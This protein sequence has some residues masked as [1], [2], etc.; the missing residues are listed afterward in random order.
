MNLYANNHDAFDS[1]DVARAEQFAAAA[2]IVLA[3]A[4][5]HCDVQQLSARLTDAMAFRGD[6]ENA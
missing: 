4:Q 6:I 1:V 5:A 2:S 3:N